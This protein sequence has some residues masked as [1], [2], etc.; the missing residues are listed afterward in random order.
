MK[1]YEVN[2]AIME[3]IDEFVD[4]E[5]GEIIGDTEEMQRR[6][7]LLEI[8]KDRILE[9]LAKLVL[10]YRA[11][12]GAIKAEVE[13][14]SDRKKK[15]ERREERI[16][17]IIDRECAGEKRDLGIAEVGYRKSTST[18][19]DNAEQAINWLETH[20]YD[21]CLKYADPTVVKSKVKALIT[22]KGIEIPGVHLA[23]KNN[24]SL[25]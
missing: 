24:M 8:E 14:L 3:T 17:A 15:L 19:I 2:L 23:E 22:K 4:V 21:D 12:Q 6:L 25:K 7:D 1:L 20:G 11:E 13:R 16:L 18:E 9:Y 10:N 5:T